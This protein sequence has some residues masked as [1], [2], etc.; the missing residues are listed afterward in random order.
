MG[1]DLMGVATGGVGPSATVAGPI[2][3][4]QG[5]LHRIARLEVLVRGLDV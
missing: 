5:K 2:V 1:G 3:V 4:V